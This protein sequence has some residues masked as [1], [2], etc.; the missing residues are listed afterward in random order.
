MVKAILV[1]EQR[2]EVLNS[3]CFANLLYAS[4]SAWEVAAVRRTK[5]SGVRN[6][7]ENARY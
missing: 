2:A 5:N 3:G 1:P 4:F 6:W 7:T